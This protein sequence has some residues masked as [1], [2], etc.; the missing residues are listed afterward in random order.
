[1]KRSARRQNR[2]SKLLAVSAH[3]L[4]EV[5]SYPPWGEGVLVTE[6]YWRACARA[7]NLMPT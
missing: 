6:R 2:F 5:A 7:Q 1:M 4:R 3:A